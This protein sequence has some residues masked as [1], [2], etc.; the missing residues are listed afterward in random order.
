MAITTGY[1]QYMVGQDEY[2]SGC[3]LIF[4]SH[5][6]DGKVMKPLASKKDA[7]AL[8]Q[9]LGDSYRAKRIKAYR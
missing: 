1:W 7:E 8:A 3:G 6:I 2:I 4:V 9:S 5:K